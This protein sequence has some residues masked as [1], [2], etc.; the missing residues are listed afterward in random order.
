M[1]KDLFFSPF[2]S[3]VTSWRKYRY[4]SWGGQFGVSKKTKYNN[5]WLECSSSPT[6]NLSDRSLTDTQDS[7]LG[8][9]QL[10]KNSHFI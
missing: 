4:F 3:S 7:V 6:V 8:L 9:E 1:A 2:T 5:F 10:K